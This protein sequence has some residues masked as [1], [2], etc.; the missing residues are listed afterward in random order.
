MTTKRLFG[1]TPGSSGTAED[2]LVGTVQ[3]II[4][5]AHTDPEP[6]GPDVVD[7]AFQFTSGDTTVALTA[8]V[9]AVGLRLDFPCRLISAHVSEMSVP[10][11]AGSAEVKFYYR[12]EGATAW[13][14][15]SDGTAVAMTSAVHGDVDITDAWFRYLEA[16]QEVTAQL[17]SVASCQSITGTLKA[18]KLTVPV[19]GLTTLMSTDRT[20]F[21]F[22]DGSLVGIPRG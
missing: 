21:T 14:D 6:D 9:P 8:T 2:R 1:S 5:K 10:S 17:M 3:S 22:T 12:N 11:I 7:L 16:G 15:I 18:R 4:R 19:S 13:T 20:P